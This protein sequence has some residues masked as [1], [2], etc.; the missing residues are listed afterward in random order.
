M[1]LSF[2]LERGEASSCVSPS[3]WSLLQLPYLRSLLCARS[4][5][6]P[7]SQLS[8]PSPNSCFFITLT[9][10]WWTACLFILFPPFI[11][12]WTSPDTD[13]AVCQS[14]GPATAAEC[15]RDNEGFWER[16]CQW[17]LHYYLSGE[18]GTRLVAGKLEVGLV[19][20]RSH[21]R[22]SRFSSRTCQ[23]SWQCRGDRWKMFHRKIG[24]DWL[25]HWIWLLPRE[26]DGKNE[27]QICCWATRWMLLSLPVEG[28][29]VIVKRV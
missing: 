5:N 13:S 8:I 19:L 20:Q 2:A 27:S 29:Q 23:Q 16:K 21:C 22:S 6:G 17:E 4:N 10:I 9:T 14:R 28:R 12:M 7:Q 1:C 24:G 25:T 11:R 15:P 26:K 18:D 3:P